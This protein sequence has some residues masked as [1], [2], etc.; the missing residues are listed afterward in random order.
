MDKGFLATVNPLLI[1]RYVNEF[2]VRIASF[3]ADTDSTIF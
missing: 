3:I 1:T 2:E